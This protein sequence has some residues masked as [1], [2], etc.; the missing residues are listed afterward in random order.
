MLLAGWSVYLS[1]CHEL[2][3]K[4]PTFFSAGDWYPERQVVIGTS[5]HSLLLPWLQI[6]A[7]CRQLGPPC[8]WIWLFT[9]ARLAGQCGGGRWAEMAKGKFSSHSTPFVDFAIAVGFM[10][11][12]SRCY[13]AAWALWSQIQP[14]WGAVTVNLNPEA[15]SP[16]SLANLGFLGCYLWGTYH[17]PLCSMENGWE[18]P[19]VVVCVCRSG[20]ARLWFFDVH[21]VAL[22]SYFCF[23]FSLQPSSAPGSENVVPREPLVR[24]HDI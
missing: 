2:I 1:A 19:E 21:W 5:V 4:N 9:F 7:E 8:G 20:M 24:S 11:V 23:Y 13:S 12:P 22:Q 3:F 17:R 18:V 14:S 16:C 10:M 15:L 6:D